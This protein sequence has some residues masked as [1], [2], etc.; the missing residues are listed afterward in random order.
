MESWRK[1]WFK[2]V[3]KIKKKKKCTHREAM[4]LASETWPK[5]KLKLQRKQQRE[6]RKL[7]KAAK[8]ETPVED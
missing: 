8:V 5:E 2:F 3:A 1:E 7:E 6:Q 4:A